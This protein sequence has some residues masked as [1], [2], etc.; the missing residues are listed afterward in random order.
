MTKSNFSAGMAK[1]GLEKSH[2]KSLP[3]E[4]ISNGLKNYENVQ[5]I[6]KKSLRQIKSSSAE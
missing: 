4:K 1:I 5:N 6:R 3:L 2:E